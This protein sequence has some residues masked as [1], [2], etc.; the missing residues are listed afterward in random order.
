MEEDPKKYFLEE[1]NYRITVRLYEASDL[2][3]PT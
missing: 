2:L 3:P 1:G